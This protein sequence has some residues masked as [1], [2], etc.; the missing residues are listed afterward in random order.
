[1]IPTITIRKRCSRFFFF[2]HSSC[3]IGA[4]EAFSSGFVCVDL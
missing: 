4:L 3:T 1:M 2:M